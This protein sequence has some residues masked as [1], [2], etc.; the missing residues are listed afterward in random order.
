MWILKTY[1]YIPSG[2]K[3]KKGYQKIPCDKLK[4]RY[5]IPKL[6]DAAQRKMYSCKHLQ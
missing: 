3:K 6:T 4:R 2:S 5:D 1:F